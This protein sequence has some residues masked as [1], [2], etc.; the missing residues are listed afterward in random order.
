MIDRLSQL[1]TLFRPARLRAEVERVAG[2]YWRRLRRIDQRVVT[3]EPNGP[4]KGSVLLSYILDPFLLGDPAKIPH[5]HTHFWESWTIA[6]TYVELG[7][8]VDCVSWTNDRFVP[9]ADYD[10]V[11]DVRTNLERWAPRLGE[12]TVKVFHADTAHWSFHN[13]AQLARLDDLEA[14]RGVRLEAHKLLPEYRG[15][16]VA[17]AV[18]VLGNAFTQETYRAIGATVL[19]VPISSPFT[20][21]LPERDWATARR[22]F[23]WFGSGALV[24]KGLDR[25]LEAFVGL[26]DLHLTVCGPIGRERDFEREYRRELY[27]TP[28]IHA[29]G[30][31][32]TRPESFVPLA[33]RHGGLV[34]PSCSEGGGASVYTCLHTGMIPLVNREVSVDVDP[35]YGMLLDDVSITGLRRAVTDF[36][37]RDPRDLGAMSRRAWAF[38]RSHHTKGAFRRAYRR[39]AE[40]LLARDFPS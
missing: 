36:A 4:V 21:D 19:H 24:H 2:K 12:S 26:P 18:T 11:I 40:R 35:A 10:L 7:Y 31:V 32:D 37:A 20:Y 25:V 14:R 17:D 22:N 3:L 34:Y 8:R 38:A 16:E 5:G 13:P 27:E 6:R 9:G 1:P 39:V 33:R 29:H 28:N 30:W 23:L 15:P